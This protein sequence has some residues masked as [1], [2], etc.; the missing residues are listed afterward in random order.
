[1]ED[2]IVSIAETFGVPELLVRFL[3]V[4]NSNKLDLS[5]NFLRH[6]TFNHLVAWYSLWV[7]HLVNQLLESRFEACR[8]LILL[9]NINYTLSVFDCLFSNRRILF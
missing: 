5:L 6:L 4:F 8:G 3:I 1:M 7:L 9:C 2:V